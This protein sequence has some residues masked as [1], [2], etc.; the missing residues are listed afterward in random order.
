LNNQ[1]KDIKEFRVHFRL[2]EY[3]HNL[4]IKIAKSKGMTKSAAARFWIEERLKNNGE[5]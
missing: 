1:K 4:L 5:A 3:S 2:S